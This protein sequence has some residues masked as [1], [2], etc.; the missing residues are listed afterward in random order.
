[1]CSDI[2]FDGDFALI[3]GLD[4]TNG[5][6]GEIDAIYPNASHPRN[7]ESVVITVN[8][9]ETHDFSLDKTLPFSHFDAPANVNVHLPD[10]CDHGREVC[11][12]VTSC[13]TTA[14]CCVS[15]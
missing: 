7:I 8:G 13:G 2:V 4:F 15:I 9:V 11:I 1:M 14:T 10:T 6:K 3:V 12:S 5:M